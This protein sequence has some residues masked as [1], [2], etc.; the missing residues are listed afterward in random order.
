[1]GMIG[2]TRARAQRDRHR[3]TRHRARPLLGVLITGTLVAT[4]APAARADV[5]GGVADQAGAAPPLTSPQQGTPESLD[6]LQYG[7]P[8]AGLDV[9]S[10]PTT[11]SYGSAQVT[12]PIDLPA[13]RLDWQPQLGL[14]YASAAEN[15]WLG[16]GWDLGVD[17]ITVPGVDAALPADSIEVDTRWGVPRYRADAESETYLFGGEQLAPNAHRGPGQPLLP[18]Q[19]DRIFTQRVEGDFLRILRHG[20]SPADYWWE[21]HDKSGNKYFYGGVPDAITG[22]GG[23]TGDGHQVADAVLTSKG[24][25]A[26]RWALTEKWDI[27]S[28]VVSYF[29][30]RVDRT[31]GATKGATQLYL[32]RINYT[33]SRLRPELAGD[34]PLPR[35]GPYD[36][37]FI[38]ASG[39]GEPQRP[40]A[41]IDARH[42]GLEVTDD[43]LRQIE[44]TYTPIGGD[45]D[46]DARLVR[47]Y[48][49]DYEIGPFAKELLTSITKSDSQGD[50][51]STNTFD[52]YDDVR[53]QEGNYHGFGSPEEWRTAGEESDDSLSRDFLGTPSGS[54]L[55]ATKSIGGDGRLFLGA[56]L[57]SP[58]KL[59]AVGGGIQLGGAD[60]DTDV[61]LIDINGD[62][63]P[64]KVWHRPNCLSG[65]SVCF[66]LN[67]ASPD[68]DTD[69]LRFG[70][71]RG[72]EGLDHLG[73]STEFSVGAG[74]EAYAG[75]NVMYNH[76]WSFSKQ[77][78]YFS[79]VNSDGLPDLVRDGDVLFNH[80]DPTTGDPEFSTD[81]GET[82]VPIQQDNS[83]PESIV[84][85]QSAEDAAQARQFPRQD[86][87]RRWV[88]PA[89]GDIEITAPVHLVEA[90]ASPDGVR[91]A[92]QH[93]GTELWTAD[94]AGGDGSD[95]VPSGVDAVHVDRGDRIYFRVGAKDNGAGDRVA[96]D[97]IIDYRDE[98]SSLDVNGKD[99]Y[100]YQGSTDFTVAGINGSVIGVPYDG[101]ITVVGDVVKSKATS[102]DVHVQL[103][104]NGVVVE[105]MCIRGSAAG[106]AQDDCDAP[107]GSPDTGTFPFA[108]EV[109]VVAPHEDANGDT[110]PGD[111]LGLRLAVD[112]T[113]DPNAV[114][115]TPQLR[116]LSA[117][118]ADGNPLPVVDPEGNPTAAL[119]APYDIDLYPN[120]DSALPQGTK[121]EED[122]LV[123]FDVDR[124]D[125]PLNALPAKMTFTAKTEDGVLRFK[126]TFTIPA[127][128]GVYSYP[129][130][131]D[132]VTG[133]G[134]A[135]YDDFDWDGHTG[136]ME[137]FFDFTF[138]DAAV[139]RATDILTGNNLPFA[140]WWPGTRVV[141]DEADVFPPPY[142]GWGYAGYKADGQREVQP[143]NEDDLTIS[144]EEIPD[145]DNP[146]ESAD[147]PDFVNPV[148][149]GS[150]PFGPMPANGLWIGP[151]FDDSDPDA[152][153]LHQ[154]PCRWPFTGCTAPRGTW[155]GPDQASASLLGRDEPG[156]P[157]AGEIITGPASAPVLY[158]KADADSL[159]AGIL[160]FGGGASS[161]LSRSVIDFLDMNGDGYP[162]AVTADEVQF[163]NQ[164]GGL[165]EAPEEVDLGGPLRYNHEY[166]EQ[167]GG[168]GSPA[169]ISTGADG[170]GAGADGASGGGGDSGSG[171]GTKSKKRKVAKVMSDL[172][173]MM[174]VGGE[175]SR[176]ATNS[177]IYPQYECAIVDCALQ[178]DLADLNGD[179]LPDRVTVEKVD[180]HAEIYVQW[181][182]GYSFTSDKV[183]FTAA[184]LAEGSSTS[185]SIN[186]S[187][188]FGTG[189]LDFSGGVDLS[190]DDERADVTWA[191][192]NSDGLDDMLTTHVDP[193][194]GDSTSVDVRLNTGTGLTSIP[195]GQF[196]EFIDS[197]VSRTRCTSI[198]GGGDFTIGIPIFEIYY[199]LINPGF[200]VSSG[201]CTPTNDLVD[202]NGDGYVDSVNSTN[203][204]LMHVS[205]NQTGRTNLLKT[206]HGPL[207]GQTDLDYARAGNTK[208][209]PA[210][211]FAL[212]KVTVDDGH[213]GPGTDQQVTTY[214]YEGG[215]QS[216]AEREDYG[217]RTVIEEQRDPSTDDVHRSWERVYANRDYYTRGL[218]ESE[219]LR[220]AT[221]TPLT[222]TVNTYELI[223]VE[224]GQ[225]AARS[226][227]TG[228]AFPAL[229]STVRRWHDAD[230][231]VV[232]S[233]QTDK[234]Y[235]ERGNLVEVSDLGEP[236]TTDDD[237]TATMTYPDCRSESDEFPWTQSPANSLLVTSGSTVLQRRDAD[238][239]CDYAAVSQVRDYLDPTSTASDKVA[240]TDVCYVPVG[241]QVS[242][243]I[244]PSKTG[245]LGTNA[246]GDD[247][248]PDDPGPG[249]FAI[250]YDYTD[251]DRL[252][253]H[254]T[255]TT[256]SYEMT[257]TSVYD[258]RFGRLV[259]T[260]D[261][262]EAT[263]S[264]TYDA[265]NRLATVTGPLE[266][267]TPYSTIAYEYHPNAPVP[268]AAAHY[269]DATDKAATIDT[270]TFVDGLGRQVETKR[271]ATVYDEQSGTAVD[272][273]VVD[274][275]VAFDPFGRVVQEF[276]ARTE[277]LGTPGQ[278]NDSYDTQHV[279]E[280][281]YDALD[282]E[283]T[284]SEPGGRTTHRSYGFDAGPFAAPMFTELQEGPGPA[285]SRAYTNVRG[286]LVGNE[287][288]HTDGGVDEPLLTT[289][290][291]DPLQRLTS[292]VD[293]TGATTTATYDL[294]GRRTSV[295]NPDTGLTEFEYDLG[296]NVTAKQ[297]P[298]LRST[299]E[300]ITYLY[301][302]F[303]TLEHVQYPRHPENNVTYE[304]GSPGDPENAAGLL[305]RVDSGARTVSMG[306]D[307]LGNVVRET[308]VMKVSDL[309]PVT[310]P[311]HTF[312]T[313]Y[314]YDTWGREL[315]MTY[316]DGEKLE[317]GYDSG[318]LPSSLQGTKNGR[319]STYVSRL[320]YDRFGNRRFRAYGNGV[321]TLTSYDPDTLWFSDQLVKKG[322]QVLS[323]LHYGYDAAGNVT[324][325]SDAR[326]APPSPQLGGPSSQTF[327]YD[328]LNRVTSATGTYRDSYRRVRTY[329][330]D[331]DFDADGR[332]LRKTQ[333]DKFGPS[334]QKQTTFDLAYDYDADQPHAPSHVGSR[335]YAW[336]DDGN[337]TSWAEDT[338]AATRTATWDEEDRMITVTDDSSFTHYGY[339]AEG[340]LS[341]VLGPSPQGEAELV[342]DRYTV[343]G[344]LGWKT[345]FIAGEDVAVTRVHDSPDVLLYYQTHDLTDTSYL[346]TDNFK[347]L[348][349]FLVLPSGQPWVQELSNLNRV[350]YPFAGGYY[351]GAKHIYGLGDRWYDPKD[352]LFYSTD[353]VLVGNLDA[354]GADPGLLDA[355]SYAANNPTTYVDETGNQP[356]SAQLGHRVAALAD[357][358]AVSAKLAYLGASLAFNTPEAMQVRDT[359]K[360]KVFTER[361]RERQK[362]T[363]RL[364]GALG[365]LA[366]PT[367]FDISLGD[368]EVFSLDEIDLNFGPVSLRD[369]G[370][371]RK[372]L[373]GKK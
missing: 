358:V 57:L 263:T 94:I 273:M 175:L 9:V 255:T 368:D 15:G 172:A 319:T 216:Y 123:H 288:L 90:A 373:R 138:A 336:D 346:V 151:K 191:D 256:D 83:I 258:N 313:R 164:N 87:V 112:S 283:T 66:R 160:G 342:N 70:E 148:Q 73:E 63:L 309:N 56:S 308:D 177:L 355:Y 217:F 244:G 150:Y 219:T 351:D 279:I 21:V 157:K 240:V 353:P 133:C 323:D 226:S 65:H 267:G 129:A 300:K 5:L 285:R 81:S 95:H 126:H 161:G 72:I 341:V 201:N 75:G 61:E 214:K 45:P 62:N 84:P 251:P 302:E 124:D 227:L 25:Q 89:E 130:P 250:T 20:D 102:D 163:T 183:L 42:G 178:K 318:G 180:E 46:T 287:L 113:I 349:H 316:P 117:Q 12:H 278:F 18:R 253:A 291:Y 221:G 43:L 199:I 369:I 67:T 198:G 269:F 35:Y 101:R 276:Y 229:V 270:V 204:G 328:D 80:L 208:G 271:D 264:Y 335:S 286:D 362:K 23:F 106:P 51:L 93:N 284:R 136:S 206:I 231:D 236:G 47:R 303:I 158:G 211:L 50:P 343:I 142:R 118:D 181:N 222:S 97:P 85:D 159:S 122:L 88:A 4:L 200:H 290:G 27:S 230:G 235:D 299:G 298:N 330:L 189:L 202:V 125:L 103:L 6:G 367:L 31:T 184:S 333:T 196:G 176:Q 321:T 345:Y 107:S 146:P 272:R 91:V 153:P 232:K 37:R 245:E 225:P 19:A 220:D 338:A 134:P 16:V 228:S 116:Y 121:A 40:D 105:D 22:D 275:Q 188:G 324:E 266:Q 257:S 314:T 152:D 145:P 114:T 143:I 241:G 82:D 60:G 261:P 8:A 364:E 233:L 69:E 190:T 247:G 315:E 371:V 98:G 218:L 246:C 74:A 311:D 363:R 179:G 3:E 205:L 320:E 168:G 192:V 34:D 144:R 348:E 331:L 41:F 111:R 193:V 68:V 119:R 96:W 58:D 137:S 155:G 110:V 64:D 182:L 359:F 78:S 372:K 32:S 252:G 289:Y 281:G 207:G 39:L 306:Y 307:K 52:Y 242:A 174:G 7:D 248:L 293:P 30:D 49:L 243:V 280:T 197:H 169:A 282:R 292:I 109:D 10:T 340:D 310:L 239:G 26:Y 254:V 48:D 167:V 301:D 357:Q 360:N 268:W 356:V 2:S 104:K 361:S 100:R 24:G 259:S 54:A 171:G 115:W 203:D 274:D 36:V 76:T 365:F 135:S 120:T 1:M 209:H 108:A 170:K 33:G 297:T 352:G 185:T 194:T 14:S 28:N 59:L 317:T 77:T 187:L 334:L 17:S 370:K 132:P 213:N 11:D 277:P 140:T 215:Q 131:C 260:T 294:L 237:I 147:D 154:V 99:V 71:K 166:G 295:D 156:A 344:G 327:S 304:Y 92:I 326:P 173:S 149:G 141:D 53:D 305:T 366:N 234:G 296:S 128:E 339:D 38:R 347:L 337:M 350:K 29:Y 165:E 249:R 86:T 195:D 79:D 212:S 238:V 332:V 312:T 262:V 322:T 13:G 325:R 162:D 223:D 265:G 44:I 186:A 127:G 329:T 55:G 354:T 139:A 210:S 224:T